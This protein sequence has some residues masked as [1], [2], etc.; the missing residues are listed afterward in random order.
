L[1]FGA[2]TAAV[3]VKAGGKIIVLAHANANPQSKPAARKHIDGGGLTGKKRGFAGWPNH[4]A[5]HQPN[6]LRRSGR[7]RQNCDRFECL[8]NHSIGDH[9]TRKGPAFSAGDPLEH[10]CAGSAGYSTR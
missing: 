5:G 9:D 4:D 6:A 8:G 10:H 2:A 3:K 1:L 7:H